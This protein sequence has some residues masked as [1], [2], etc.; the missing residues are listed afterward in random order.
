V[1][2]SVAL[3]KQFQAKVK[4]LL[5]KFK[6]VFAWSYKELKGFPRSICEHKIKLI[7]DACPMKQQPYWMNLNY[8]QRIREDLDTLLDTLI[9]LPYWNYPMDITISNCTKK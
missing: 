3:I 1:L 4:Q 6:G 7:I 8:A 2:V 9:Y 5:I